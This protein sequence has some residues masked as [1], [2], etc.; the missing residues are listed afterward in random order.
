MTPVVAVP[1][2]KLSP[3]GSELLTNDQVYGD[4]PPEAVSVAL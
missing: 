4:T 2:L 1:L 3:V